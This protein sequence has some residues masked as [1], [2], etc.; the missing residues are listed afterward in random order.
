M[1][2][3]YDFYKQNNLLDKK[4][5]I[6]NTRPAFNISDEKTYNAF[7]KYFNKAGEYILKSDL[8]N[9]MDKFVCKNILETTSYNDYIGKFPANV[10][11]SYIRRKK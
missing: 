2:L 3:I 4:I 6:Y 5:K 1:E 10:A 8:Y 11:I 9:D 7:K